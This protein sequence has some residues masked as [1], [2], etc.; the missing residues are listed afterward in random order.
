MRSEMSM[1]TCILCSTNRIVFPSACRSRMTAV[2]L[3]TM[4][5]ERPAMGSSRRRRWAS[6]TDHDIVEHAEAAEYPYELEGA[7][8][9]TPRDLVGWQA[10]DA[11]AIQSDI[12]F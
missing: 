12:A 4:S 3:R 8:D 10:V 2:I 9:P 5:W 1:T 7:H 11:R 6:A